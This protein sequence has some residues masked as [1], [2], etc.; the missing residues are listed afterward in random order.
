M[1]PKKKE[2]VKKEEEH[3]DEAALP[4]WTSFQLWLH[5]HPILHHS[6][7]TFLASLSYIYK[8]VS[9]A[10]L[11][12]L[13]VEKEL[14]TAGESPSPL[15]LAKAYRLKITQLELTARIGKRDKVPR[16]IEDKKKP[17]PKDVKGKDAKGKLPVS[18]RNDAD[19]IDP[20]LPEVTYILH[21]Y[22]ASVE[23]A[24]ALYAEGGCFNMMLHCRPTEEEIKANYEKQR[25]AYEK[26]VAERQEKIEKGEEPGAE[27]TAPVSYESHPEVF[28][29]LQR[30]YV[31]SPCE[32]PAH[33]ACS[34][35]MT[36]SDPETADMS[37]EEKDLH[38]SKS[39]LE[40]IK[41]PAKAYL[42]YDAWLKTIKIVPIP[43][44]DMKDKALYERVL[45]DFQENEADE[46]YFLLCLR[47]Q[48]L[49]SSDHRH[50]KETRALERHFTELWNDIAL[51]ME[52]QANVDVLP[53]NRSP[54]QTI[55]HDFD[56]IKTKSFK[57]PLSKLTISELIQQIYDELQLPGL[58]R[59]MMPETA[60]KTEAERGEERTALESFA[61]IPLSSFHRALI[62]TQFES[63]L[64]KFQPERQWNFG[65]RVYEERLSTSL[66][67]QILL[68]ALLLG[69]DV[70]TRYDE[71]TDS[72]L[73]AVLHKAPQGRVYR[74]RW[75][76]PWRAKPCFEHWMSVMKTNDKNQ[77]TFLDV[78][79]AVTGEIREKT[80][81]FAPADDSV[82]K[83]SEL[84][85]GPRK[86]GKKW[87]KEA[88]TSYSRVVVIKD[89]IRFG[90]RSVLSKAEFWTHF[91]ENSRLLVEMTA[92]GSAV[93][94]G[95]ASGL[96]A[97][98]LPDGSVVQQCDYRPVC[99]YETPKLPEEVEE[100]NRVVTLKGTVIRYM[101][102]S[103]IQ[104]YF[105]NGNVSTRS[106]DKIW[107]SVNNKGRRRAKRQKDGIEYQLDSL[108]VSNFIDPETSARVI[109]RED[110]TIV[111]KYA[112][113]ASVAIH[114]DGTKMYTSPTKTKIVVEHPRFA[115]VHMTLD[116]VKARQHTIIGSRSTDSVL[117]AGDV[118]RRSHDGLILEVRLDCGLSVHSFVQKQEVEGFNQF[119][120]NRVNL[121]EAQDGT[122]IKTQQDGEVAIVSGGTRRKL[123]EKAGGDPFAYF[124]ELFSVPEDRS[125]G[126]Y[127]ADLKSEVLWTKDAEGNLFSVGAAGGARAKLAVSLNIDDISGQDPHSPVFSD[128]EFID[129]ESR[130]LPPPPSIPDPRLFVIS[131]NNEATEYLSESQLSSYFLLQQKLGGVV[132]TQEVGSATAVSTT[133]RPDIY[134]DPRFVESPLER[135]GLPSAVGE[136]KQTEP[137]PTIAQPEVYKTRTF[138]KYASFTSDD[139][140]KFLD[141]L[142]RFKEWREAKAAQRKEWITTDPRTDADRKEEQ[143][144]LAK[145]QAQLFGTTEVQKSEG[146][147]EL[148]KSNSLE[149]GVEE[150][151]ELQ[152]AE[153]AEEEQGSLE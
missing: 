107:Q 57:L 22:P 79:S 144:A 77:E 147:D 55:L 123:A 139:R 35:V 19:E 109:I 128:G 141:D 65:D 74:K 50:E 82:V 12:E 136:K 59:Y 130:F 145:I 122:V 69:P 6:L 131:A 63:S 112:D 73:V 11:T 152:E 2:V 90:V 124:Y 102:N 41:E 78:D 88:S 149:S 135:Y 111:V 9:R 17:A 49:R 127:T 43:F 70:V 8:A 14:L 4:P 87:W 32:S 38:F 28:L 94:L 117:G 110:W 25:L 5:L 84:Y 40:A 101:K 134:P 34:K 96:V 116:P 23:E 133:W 42:K 45:W 132:S 81:I 16:A 54:P 146:S 13:A 80:K 21:D 67:G 137:L 58:K 66:S 33:Q 91:R 106:T 44:N 3:V 39:I 120:V 92:T 20:D 47:A 97:K 64:K 29:A 37:E 121:I 126:V 7:D 86:T 89:D 75:H 36:Y 93:S 100:I 114:K 119:S 138:F 61:S 15:I 148:V 10:E 68:E 51:S 18:P 24:Q 1:P 27:P 95:S 115:S 103:T 105:A 31:N 52:T 72:L 26:A 56:H 76:Y 140:A 143:A 62:L 104:I 150:Q 113:G 108:K 85:V 30:L 118:M 98:I 46:A 53:P 129:P 153:Q 60:L 48:V 71:L 83:A 142:Q 99:T 125:Y 151:E